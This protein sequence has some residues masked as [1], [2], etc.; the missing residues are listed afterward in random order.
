MTLHY[1]AGG[2]IDSNGQYSA[3]TA[4]FNLA[5]VQ[6]VDQ[7]NA[8]PAGTKGLVW[9][10]QGNGVT[11]SF[12]DAVTPYIGNSKLEG[13]YLKDEP[14][15]TGKYGTLVTA[16]NLKAESDWIHAHVP[17]AS[18]FITMMN[19]GSSANPDFT[20]T[21]NPTNTHID[22]FGIDPYPVRSGSGAVDYNMIDKAVAAAEQS[23]IPA[24]KIVPVYQTFGGGGWATDDGGKYVMP[25]AQQ[26]QTMLDHWAKLVP[27]PHFDY[28]Y[29]WNSQNG[30]T[31][32]SSSAELQQ[33]F[34]AHNTAG[35][36]ATSGST[37][38][39]VDTATSPVAGSAD[40]GTGST[41]TTTG[42]STGTS[43]DVTSGSSSGTTDSTSSST[44]TTTHASG[45]T[46]GSTSAT[47][48]GNSGTSADASTG[49]TTGTVTDNTSATTTDPNTGGQATGGQHH[50]WA[51]HH[52]AAA[53]ADAFQFSQFQHHWDHHWG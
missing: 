21:Y 48:G 6:S 4:G 41:S 22:Y 24:D 49:G 29:A 10:D 39:V 5:D 2:G 33:V 28:A 12:I 3:G 19:M 37:G 11:Q 47:T 31:A 52:D 53:T 15:P 14:D 30:D 46:T 34:L 20:N 13:F 17:G 27:A 44:G 42:S 25:T 38:S 40:S 18:T 23:G 50:H 16:D 35:G 7:L 8:L 32:L 9:L 51:G 36:T 43:T 45:G 1:A 26:E